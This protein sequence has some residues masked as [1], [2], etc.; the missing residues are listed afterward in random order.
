MADIAKDILILKD[1]LDTV[2][3]KDL[4]GMVAVQLL[5]D[6]LKIVSEIASRLETLESQVE[7]LSE[8]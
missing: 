3:E 2:E 7:V 5:D 4:D 8:K 1:R 6:M